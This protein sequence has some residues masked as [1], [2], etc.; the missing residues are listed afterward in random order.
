MRSPW[1]LTQLNK[2]LK[3]N[4]EPNN[5][6]FIDVSPFPRVV[7]EVNQPLVFSGVKKGHGMS[8]QEIILTWIY[9][10]HPVYNS[11]LNEGFS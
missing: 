1:C 9:I 6:W 10:P 5:W 4:M 8:L 2:P 7:F 11:G 3:T